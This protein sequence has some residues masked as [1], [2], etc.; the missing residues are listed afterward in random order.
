MVFVIKIFV[1]FLAFGIEELLENF[2]VLNN[3]VNV[4]VSFD[5]SI[6][7]HAEFAFLVKEGKL[8]E[9]LNDPKIS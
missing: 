1:V 7:K 8:K 3:K 9:R 2:S 6:L 4:W 5:V